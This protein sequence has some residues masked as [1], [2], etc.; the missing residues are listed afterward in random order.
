MSEDNII[1][2]VDPLVS[3][4]GQ[5]LAVKVSCSR[6]TFTSR[7]LRLGTGFKHSDGPPVSHRPVE[8]IPQQTH[9]GKPQYGRIGSFARLDSWGSSMLQRNDSLSISFWCQPTL[10]EGANHRQYLFSSMNDADCVGFECFLDT[11]AELRMRIGCSRDVHDIAFS[12]KFVR[13]RWYHLLFEI[14]PSSGVVTLNAKAK[15]SGISEQAELFDEKYSLERSIRITSHMPLTVGADSLGCQPTP[16]PRASSSFNGKVDR[17]KLETASGAGNVTTLLDLDFS[18]DMPTDKVRD[19]SGNEHH[20]ELINGPSRAVTGHDWDASQTAWTHASYGYGAIHFHDDDLDDAMWEPSFQLD[21]PET[22][23][24]GC[25][26]IVVDD[27]VSTDFIP[28]FLR[29]DPNAIRNPPVALIIPTLTYAAYANERLHDDSRKL[30]F[31]CDPDKKDKYT[32]TLTKRPDLGISLYDT[33]NDGSG[34]VFSSLKRPVLKMR[35]DYS[36][37][38]F[39]GPKEL[40]ADLWFVDF[41][42]RELGVE[43]YDVITDHDISEY[44]APLLKKYRVLLSCSHPEYPTYGMLDSYAAFLSN[45]GRFM[46][47]GGNGY[48]WVTGHDPA[49]PHRIE[50][51]RAEVGCRTFELPPGNWHHS[52]TGGLGGLWR[53]RG[54]PPNQLFGIGSCAEGVGHGSGYGIEDEARTNEQFSFMFRGFESEAIIGENALVMGAAS[55]DEIDRMDYTLGEQTLILW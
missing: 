43:G 20:G 11:A 55:G 3:S 18:L 10:P 17:F 38:L 4:P 48:Y 27:G 29:P 16:K 2:Y 51:R 33:H 1:G 30:H 24:S 28:F 53:S 49:R 35:P 8:A 19:V 15:A 44:G 47:L 14:W 37:W 7:V 13:H 36:M 42:D 21:L 22:L 6:N 52:L 9:Q 12:L 50:V 25:Y 40:S 23:P 39:D 45:G 5:K 54:R 32:Q 34:T 41:L 31:P 26:G 46:Y